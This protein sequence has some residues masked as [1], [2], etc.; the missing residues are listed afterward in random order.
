MQATWQTPRNCL[1]RWLQLRVANRA[2]AGTA[3]HQ[4]PFC[5]A[6]SIQTG[7]CQE[8]VRADNSV[9]M[10]FI[11]AYAVDLD[12]DGHGR[13]GTRHYHRGQCNIAYQIGR[14]GC[15][16]RCNSRDEPDHSSGGIV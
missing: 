3:L 10:H 15:A 9:G 6:P 1:P 13:E 14:I 12:I 11:A 4:G 2:D 8:D 16:T 7:A 5:N